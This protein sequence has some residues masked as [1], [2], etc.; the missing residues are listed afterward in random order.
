MR[1]AAPSPKI[2]V[3]VRIGSIQVPVPTIAGAR[4][5]KTTTPT[6]IS[7][8]GQALR[9]ELRHPAL[10]KSPCGR[11]ASTSASSANVNT[12]E[13]CVQ[14]SL[15]VVGRYAGR[16]HEHDPIEQ[17]SRD[18]AEQRAHAADDHDH[19]RVEQPLAVL[20]LRDVALGRADDGA[21]AREAGAHDER[22]REDRLDVDPERRGH[23]AVVDAGADHHPRLRLVE[24][25]V[26]READEDA[27]RQHQQPRQ[28]VLDTEEPR[29]RRIGRS[30]RARRC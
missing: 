16:E 4:T 13:Y 28:R 2:S 26:E 1:L 18:G 22:D 7:P 3:G 27:E 25:E 11:N 17:R 20:E 15:P 19:E 5:A 29:G 8:L 30:S 24:P 23:L 9:L 6:P 10:P 14:Q 12:I 21:Q